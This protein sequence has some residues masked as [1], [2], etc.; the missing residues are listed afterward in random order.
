MHAA[1]DSGTQPEADGLLQGNNVHV[2][3]INDPISS[4]KTK[5][6]NPHYNL[7]Y[8]FNLNSHGTVTLHF[9]PSTP[10]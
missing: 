9:C 2:I 8:A 1:L 6:I 7:R 4:M 10:P 3:G 5:N